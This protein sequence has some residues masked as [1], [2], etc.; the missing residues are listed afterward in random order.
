MK[1]RYLGKLKSLVRRPHRP[2]AQ[3]FKRLSEIENFR[4][5]ASVHKTSCDNPNSVNQNKITTRQGVIDK[6]KL[7]D[8]YVLLNN[9]KVLHVKLIEPNGEIFGHISNKLI[10]FYKYPVNSSLL[11]IYTT[12]NFAS[13]LSMFHLDEIVE[14]C[15]VLKSADKYVICKFLH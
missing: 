5:M 2:L 4:F 8:S 13:D 7:G 10:P 14:K 11:G 6:F 12:E 1:R 3:I 9:L 15:F